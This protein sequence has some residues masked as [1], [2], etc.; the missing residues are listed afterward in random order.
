MRL[1]CQ[2]RQRRRQSSSKSKRESS[3]QNRGK[4]E[5]HENGSAARQ[6]SPFVCHAIAS[7]AAELGSRTGEA[8][9]RRG[10]FVVFSSWKFFRFVFI[11]GCLGFFFMALYT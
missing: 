3:P 4:R 8:M 1:R 11:D 6:N 10:L 2:G 9:E 5:D 7:A